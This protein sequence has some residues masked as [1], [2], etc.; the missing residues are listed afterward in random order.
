L[1]LAYFRSS[2]IVE[3]NLVLGGAAGERIRHRP[4]RVVNAAKTRAPDAKH[5]LPLYERKAALYSAPV[6]KSFRHNGLAEFFAAGKSAKVAGALRKRILRRLDALDAAAALRE[7][8]Q[9]GFDFHRLRGFD[10]PRYTIHVNGPWCITFEWNGDG[11]ARI[12][13]EQYH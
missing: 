10:S 2:L 4:S 1:S 9:P 8:D 6:I 3:T 12:D 5:H 11:P 7:L 13:L